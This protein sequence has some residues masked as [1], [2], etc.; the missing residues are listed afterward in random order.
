MGIV[1]YK[2]STIWWNLSTTACILHCMSWFLIMQLKYSGLQ[3]RPR[4]SIVKTYFS[5]HIPHHES[6]SNFYQ[7]FLHLWNF[8]WLSYFGLEWQAPCL[9]M[10]YQWIVDRLKMS[11]SEANSKWGWWGG[12]SLTSQKSGHCQAKIKNIKTYSYV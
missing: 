8:F 7:W 3:I 2:C 4:K 11:I 12:G 10:N 5:V 1:G 9:K 6:K